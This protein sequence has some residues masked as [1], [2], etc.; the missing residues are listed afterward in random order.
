M[1]ESRGIADQRQ[2]IWNVIII[3]YSLEVSQ[4]AAEYS[5]SIGLPQHQ[6]PSQYSVSGSRIPAE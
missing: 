2:S 6:V 3:N 1:S 4:S 5:I